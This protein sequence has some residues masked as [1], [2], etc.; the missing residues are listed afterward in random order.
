[1]VSFAKYNFATIKLAR[2][3]PEQDTLNI[4]EFKCLGWASQCLILRL[5]QSPLNGHTTVRKLTVSFQQVGLKDCWENWSIN[6][7]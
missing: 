7:R 4:N 3:W 1:M 6:Y 5:R 2:T